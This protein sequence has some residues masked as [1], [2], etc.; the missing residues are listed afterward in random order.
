MIHSLFKYG[1]T[2]YMS[3]LLEQFVRPTLNFSR[4]RLNHTGLIIN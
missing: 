1:A 2:L 3:V 4:E